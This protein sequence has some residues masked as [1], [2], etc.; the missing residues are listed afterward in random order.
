[1]HQLHVFV[2]AYDT[3]LGFK[4][5]DLESDAISTILLWKFDSIRCQELARHD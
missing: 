1:M 5:Q 3:F 4:D 2:M